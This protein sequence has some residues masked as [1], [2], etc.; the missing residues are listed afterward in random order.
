MEF[1]YFIKKKIHFD[2]DSYTFYNVDI[3][4]LCNIKNYSKH[5]KIKCL[6]WN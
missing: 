1:I 2:R 6:D 5:F 3:V 4:T